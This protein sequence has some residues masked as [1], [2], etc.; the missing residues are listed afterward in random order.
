MYVYK[1]TEVNLYTVGFYT[2]SGEWEPESDQP[3]AEKAAERVI[4]LNGG[5]VLENYGFCELKLRKPKCEGPEC[6]AWA[7]NCGSNVLT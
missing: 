6:S 2:P 4:K 3:T 1:R 7:D 5:T